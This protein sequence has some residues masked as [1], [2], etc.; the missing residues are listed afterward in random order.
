MTSHGE[1]KQVEFI[2][3]SRITTGKA[4]DGGVGNC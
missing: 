3:T 4:W 2:D 1:S